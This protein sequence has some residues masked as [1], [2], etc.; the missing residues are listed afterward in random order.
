VDGEGS[1]VIR[2]PR[3]ELSQRPCSYAYVFKL[4]GFEATLNPE[5][6]FDQPDAIWLLPENASLEG[7]EIQAVPSGDRWRIS[8]WNNPED[9]A[10][11]TAWVQEAGVYDVRAELRCSN[12]AASSLT[13]EVAGQS[14]TAEIDYMEGKRRMVEMGT[15]TFNT[16]GVYHFVLSP[17]SRSLWNRIDVWEVRLARQRDE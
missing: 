6:R 2:P 4:S 13:L 3:L 5:V 15:L 16:S 8:Q 11:W 12:F 7:K 10:H 9:R 17:A 1:V 14:T